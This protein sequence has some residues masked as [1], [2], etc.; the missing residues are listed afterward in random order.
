MKSISLHIYDD[1]A[2]DSRLQ[3]ALD[4]CRALDAHLSCIQVTP[5]DAQISFDPIGGVY[6]SGDLINDLRE[7]EVAVRAQIEARLHG[8]DVRWDWRSYDG[9]PVQTMIAAST[10][11]D[12]VVLSQAS[13]AVNLFHRPL[14]LAGDL[15]L[16]AGCPVLMVP[17]AAKSI[18]LAGRVTIAWNGSA[19][20]ARA[21]RQ[22]IGL[23]RI[24]TAVDLVSVGDDGTAFPQVDASAYLA[25]HDI[26]SELH[27][28]AGSAQRPAQ[29]ILEFA[30]SRGASLVIM[31]AY[32]HS[33]LRETLL[34]GATRDL[35]ASATLPLLLA[36]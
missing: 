13:N 29:A 31:G 23:L 3:V 26:G 20:A 35:L 5:Y 30:A 15:A 16:H 27:V 34:G 33:R 28:I 18:E 19:E 10:L 11:S 24:A 21:I 9:E 1:D 7:R 2:L 4:V 8:E 32:G 6:I 22:S 36:H 25:R 14:P 12:L 17:T